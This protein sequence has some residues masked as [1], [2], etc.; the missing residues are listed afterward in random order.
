MFKVILCFDNI[1]LSLSDILIFISLKI[2][3]QLSLFSKIYV[4]RKY[5]SSVNLSFTPV[6]LLCVDVQGFF[7]S[8]LLSLILAF[9][10]A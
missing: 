3:F 8:S 9:I 7:V 4:I 6:I 1:K 10:I 2:F 5:Y